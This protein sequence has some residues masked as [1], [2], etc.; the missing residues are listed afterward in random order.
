MAMPPALLKAIQAKKSGKSNTN[1][2]HEYSGDGASFPIPKKKKKR[3]KG[4]QD[5][6]A[7][8]LAGGKGSGRN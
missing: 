3:N 5:A 7:R 4:Q 6:I 1:G 2:D 8:R